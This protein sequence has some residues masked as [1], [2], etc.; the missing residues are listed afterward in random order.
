M[1]DLSTLIDT[2]HTFERTVEAD[3]CI[4]FLSDRFE[5]V[6]PSLATPRMILWMEHTCRDAIGPQLPE[7]HDSV[8][9][10]VEVA[11]LGATPLGKTVTFTAKVVAVDGKKVRFAVA[12]R[13]PEKL[14]GEGFHERHVID[15]VRFARKLGAKS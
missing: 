6:P 5:G 8:G 2:E 1:D 3:D 11:H 7:F 12:A 13:D 10:R 4:T 14:V 15:V 9:I